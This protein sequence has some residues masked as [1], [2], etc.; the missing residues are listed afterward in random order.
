MSSF[1]IFM[2]STSGRQKE[3]SPFGS[4]KRQL[5]GALIALLKFLYGEEDCPTWRWLLTTQ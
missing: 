1:P 5:W 4:S 3:F 2:D